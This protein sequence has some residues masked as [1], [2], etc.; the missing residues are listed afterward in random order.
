MPKDYL[1]IVTEKS[2]MIQRHNVR[3]HSVTSFLAFWLMT[4]AMGGIPTYQI[5]NDT[6]M[7]AIAGILDVLQNSEIPPQC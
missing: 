7:G 5:S 3:L 1:Y 6:N 2:M 4:E